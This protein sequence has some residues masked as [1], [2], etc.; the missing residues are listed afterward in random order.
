M[1]RGKHLYVGMQYVYANVKSKL[2]KFNLEADDASLA[3]EI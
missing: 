3:C 1:L 2:L